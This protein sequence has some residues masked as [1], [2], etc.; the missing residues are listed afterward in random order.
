MDLF[1]I[2]LNY[3]MMGSAVG[4]ALYHL[5]MG[6]KLLEFYIFVHLF[7]W[8]MVL[9]IGTLVE[10]SKLK[11]LVMLLDEKARRDPEELYLDKLNRFRNDN[12]RSFHMELFDASLDYG[13]DESMPTID[14]EHH[15]PKE[16]HVAFFTPVPTPTVTVFWYRRD[17]PQRQAAGG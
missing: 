3:I 2:V 6:I 5:T 17:Y 11:A 16:T 1:L 7:L 15:T 14:F 10:R 4:L 8:Y 13:S 12:K 9:L